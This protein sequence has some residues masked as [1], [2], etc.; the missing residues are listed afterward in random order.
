M[1]AVMPKGSAAFWLGTTFHGLGA[2]V[3]GAP[4]TGIIYSF[5]VDR[6]TQEENQFTAVPPAIAATLSKR[7]QQLIGY[8]SSSALNFIEGLDDGHVLSR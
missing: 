8:H 6:F 4:R 3:T 2:S 7:A 1:Q 5:V